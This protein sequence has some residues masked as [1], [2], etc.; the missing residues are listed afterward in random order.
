MTLWVEVSAL[1]IPTPFQ[2]VVVGTPSERILLKNKPKL[3]QDVG[4]INTVGESGLTWAP[5]C[6]RIAQQ[7]MIDLLFSYG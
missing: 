3:P 2:P 4:V 5:L 6:A 1:R 7:V